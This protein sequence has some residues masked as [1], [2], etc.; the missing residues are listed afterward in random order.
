MINGGDLAVLFC[1]ELPSLSAAGSVRFSVGKLVNAVQTG[2]YFEGG[3]H[4]DIDR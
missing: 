1:V 4:H 2:Q 3:P